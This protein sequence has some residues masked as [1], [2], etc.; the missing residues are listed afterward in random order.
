MTWLIRFVFWYFEALAD[1][2]FYSTLISSQTTFSASGRRNNCPSIVVWVTFNIH[3][4]RLP[5]SKML[6]RKMDRK[7]PQTR[8]TPKTPTSIYSETK[9]MWTWIYNI[10]C[11]VTRVT[12]LSTF[13]STVL[14]VP[15]YR[16]IYVFNKS[17]ETEEISCIYFFIATWAEQK[18]PFN[19][20]ENLVGFI[21]ATQVTAI[22]RATAARSPWRECCTMHISPNYWIRQI[23]IWITYYSENIQID[24][25]ASCMSDSEQI[26]YRF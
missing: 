4:T 15:S 12:T 7:L 17:E 11:V 14:L 22:I 21:S 3:F 20:S 16:W 2:Q 6:A 19:E 1:S 5:G 8:I 9:F 26:L 18:P 13:S 10:R 23:W 24:E 25:M